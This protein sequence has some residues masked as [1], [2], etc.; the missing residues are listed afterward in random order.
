MKKEAKRIKP[1][2]ILIICIE[3]ILLEIETKHNVNNVNK[4]VK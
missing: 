1:K 4:R 3:D 2:E